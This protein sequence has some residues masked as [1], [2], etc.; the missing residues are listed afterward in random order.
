MTAISI[1]PITG[2]E[3]IQVIDILRGIALL[4]IGLVHAIFI[5]DGDILA[6]YALMGIFLLLLRKL[7]PKTLVLL[8]VILVVIQTGINFF[9]LPS[10]FF[11]KDLTFHEIL[12][13]N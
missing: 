5:W 3:R 12:S 13:K 4:V 7:T 2:K 11:S 6:T 8:A 10:M 9:W 1:S